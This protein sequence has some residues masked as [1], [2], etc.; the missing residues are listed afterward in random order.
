MRKGFTLV[1]AIIAIGLFTIVVSIA[2]GG[3]INALHTQHEV[4]ALLA[5]QSSASEALEQMTRE[6]RTGYLFC[7]D[8]NNSTLKQPSAACQPYTNPINGGAG[9]WTVDGYINFQNANS[10]NVVYEVVNGSLERQNLS[11]SPSTPEE[12]T[13]SN[14]AVKYLIFTLA[15]NTEGDHWNPRITISMGVAP[16]STDPAVANDVMNL[17]TTVS[18]RSIDCD[19]SAGGANC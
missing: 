6:M 10:E 1:E 12:I 11:A 15:G 19:V 13:G 18:A 9:T 7:V 8:P 3:F 14:V 16:S 4:S 2:S 5:A 17:E